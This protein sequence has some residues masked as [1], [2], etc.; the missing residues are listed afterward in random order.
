VRDKRALGSRWLVYDKR[1]PLDVVHGTVWSSEA[2]FEARV[3]AERKFG[4]SLGHQFLWPV[5]LSD[6]RPK[7]S[8]QALCRA[9]GLTMLRAPR[10]PRKRRR[11]AR[12]VRRKK[13]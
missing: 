5:R 8:D 12:A 13:R 7:L 9:L 11:K 4:D 1:A 3:A 6:P 2:W 10:E